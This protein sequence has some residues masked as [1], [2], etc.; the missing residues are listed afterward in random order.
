MSYQ[1]VAATGAHELD[2]KELPQLA[3][4]EIVDLHDPIEYAIVINI[5]R[6]R[7]TI[8]IAFNFWDAVLAPQQGSNLCDLLVQVVLRI[9]ETPNVT[10]GDISLLGQGD[11]DLIHYWNKDMPKEQSAC[12]PDLILGNCRVEPYRAAICAWDGD[13]TYH[14]LDQLS[15]SLAAQF[16]GL[17]IRAEVFV[18]LLLE[19]SKWVAVAILAVMRAGGAFVL[20]DPSYPDSR[21]QDICGTLRSEVVVCPPTTCDRG[22]RFG[23][24]VVVMSA[25]EAEQWM[26][27]GETIASTPT[28]Q[29]HN[30]AYA[31]FT[32]GSS[33]KPKDVV[34]EH[35]NYPTS[36]CSLEKRLQVTPCSRVFQ[37]AS[38]AFDVSVSDY[39]TTLIAG[40]CVCIPSE[41]DRLNNIA[42]AVRHLR[43]NWIHIT[44]S[45][46]Q[47][48][49]PSQTP[50]IET[51]VLSSEVMKEDNIRTWGRC[52]QLI[53]AYGPAECSVDCVVNSDNVV[54]P[55]SIG[56]ASGCVCWVTDKNDPERLLPI[57]AVGELLVEGPV[58]GRGYLNNEEQ[59]HK[60]F[61]P[62]PAW[63]R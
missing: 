40:G 13:L 44:P 31:V 28:A 52:V 22:L 49:H 47:T 24:H 62:S 19:K 54:H 53:N 23:K 10:A 46:A 48:F 18:P 8:S 17:G 50:D 20:L 9:I 14:E 36:G 55:A 56:T 43:A 11:L 21:L 42:D 16:R 59:T 32:S 57:S 39:L 38:H 41:S 25:P 15:S 33:G 35:Y 3:R 61:I 5:E 30:A 60:S 6:S 51:M 7:N 34:V 63:L 58:V 45:I 29:P 12:L 4:L 37:F 1:T 2:S 27:S 26:S